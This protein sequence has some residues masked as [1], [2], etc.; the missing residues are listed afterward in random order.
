ML[1]RFIRC[2]DCGV[3]LARQMEA[4]WLLPD[5]AAAQLVEPRFGP[6]VRELMADADVQRAPDASV[7]TWLRAELAYLGLTAGGHALYGRPA[8]VR[9]GHAPR[10]GRQKAAIVMEER[11]GK[12]RVRTAYLPEEMA[13]DEILPGDPPGVWF[14]TRLGERPF[15]GEKRRPGAAAEEQDEGCEAYCLSCRRRQFISTRLLG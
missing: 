6:S 15:L 13:V 9:G 7:A 2:V 14:R 3:M 1:V 5:E 11:G 12:T 8:H 10:R 4:A